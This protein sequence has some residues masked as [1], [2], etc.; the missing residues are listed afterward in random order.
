MSKY[1]LDRLDC[2]IIDIL[3]RNARTSLLEIGRECNVSGAAIHQRVQKLVASGVIDHFETLLNPRTLDLNLRA[4]IGVV[5]DNPADAP[6]VIE[7]L[8]EIPEVVE[9]HTVS[10]P[11]DFIIKV[12]AR[13]SDHLYSLLHK[14]IEPVGNFRTDTFLSFKENVRRQIKVH[15]NK[16]VVNPFEG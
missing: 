4:F 3:S 14:S 16:R 12:F 9:C 10:G 7:R 13:D 2:K 8:R 11:Y 6:Q 15:P 1:S 5:L